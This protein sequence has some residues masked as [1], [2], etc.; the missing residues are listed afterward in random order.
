[1]TWIRFY[2]KYIDKRTHR[3]LCNGHRYDKDDDRFIVYATDNMWDRQDN[4]IINNPYSGVPYGRKIKITYDSYGSG[5]YD[6][7]EDILS[8]REDTNRKY[9]PNGRFRFPIQ[10]RMYYEGRPPSRPSSIDIIGDGV[11]DNTIKGNV[12]FS[13]TWTTGSYATKY[14]LEQKINNEDWVEVYSGSQKTVTF[15]PEDNWEIVQY[16]VRSYNSDGYSTFQT[17]N[18]Y[19][20]KHFPEMFAK[21]DGNIVNIAQGWVKIDGSLKEINSIFT[22]IDET[23]VNC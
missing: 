11:M 23:I 18:I 9:T 8:S 17:A 22:K 12:S 6:S 2:S 21:V 19:E 16:R 15:T 4:F 5:D 1:M 7:W 13:V 20:V 14:Y 3:I 10:M